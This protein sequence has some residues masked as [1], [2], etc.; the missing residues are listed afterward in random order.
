MVAEKPAC[1]DD[2]R[3]T[4]LASHVSADHSFLR[5]GLDWLTAARNERAIAAML[6][7][8]IEYLQLHFGQEEKVDGLFDFLALRAPRHA[9]TVERLRSQHGQILADAAALRGE[10][11]GGSSQ[12]SAEQRARV[13]EFVQLLREHEQLETALLQDAYDADLGV[14]D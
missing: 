5:S 9:S 7:D 11:S 12:V 14:G 2:S 6:E 1:N 8:L 10:L 4:D 3:P 13:V